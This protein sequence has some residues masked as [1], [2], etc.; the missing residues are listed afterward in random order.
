MRHLGAVLA[1][2]AL[3][4][5]AAG[6]AK[7]G[8]ESAGSG[9]TTAAPTTTRIATGPA[10][11]GVH[12]PAGAVPV[13][14]GQVDAHAL[15]ASFSREV[16]TEKGGTVLGFYGEDGGCFTSSAAV[17][18]Q[19]A[20]EVVVRLV[21]QEPGTGPRACPMYLR[22]KPMSVTLADPLGSRTVVLRL[23]IMRG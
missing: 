13:P 4:V 1:A 7:Q 22:Y 19:T 15:P 9:L 17:T 8:T 2:G 12:L 16:W 10:M 11:P 21:Q 18:S 5:L 14:G 20:Q 3:L 6:C 23:A